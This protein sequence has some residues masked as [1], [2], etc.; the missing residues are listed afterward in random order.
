[1]AKERYIEVE[2]MIFERIPIRTHVLAAGDDV[3]EVVGRYLR[4][5]GQAGDW[6][7][8]S[9]KAVAAT[10]GRAIPLEA[11]TPSKWARF[12][13]RFVRKVPYGI[14]L[15]IPETMEAAIREVGLARILCA[16]AAASVTRPFGWRGV[17]YRVAGRKASAIDG[18]TPYSIPPYNQCVVLA[19]LDP[20]GVC[21]L[22]WESTGYETAIVDVNDHGSE[23]LGATPGIH[24]EV[25]RRILR[26]N[27]LGQSRQQTPIGI[28]RFTES[29]QQ[30]AASA[31]PASETK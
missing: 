4:G 13:C 17:F 12:L 28:V 7:A 9:E 19:P 25:L 16:A 2:G 22:I 20:D 21:R 14:G 8:L 6:I 11:I 29:Q 18:P 23:V 5:V 31:A 24:R 26:D 1:M 10:Q 15:G 3:A 27:P 30:V